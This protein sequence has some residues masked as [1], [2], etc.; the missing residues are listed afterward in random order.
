MNAAGCS[1]LNRS[2]LGVLWPGRENSG[3]SPLSVAPRECPLQFAKAGSAATLPQK[4]RSNSADAQQRSG[5]E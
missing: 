3:Y 4:E 5:A 1:Y 2:V